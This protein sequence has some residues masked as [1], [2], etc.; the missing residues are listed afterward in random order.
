MT[1]FVEALKRAYLSGKIDEVRLLV[2]K[3]E[4]KITQEEYDYITA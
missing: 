4:G 1:A 2:L 3:K